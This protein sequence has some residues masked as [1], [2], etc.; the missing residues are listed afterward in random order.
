MKI[1]HTVCSLL[2]LSVTGMPSFAQETAKPAKEPTAEEKAWMAYATPGKAHEMMAKSAGMWSEEVTMWMAPGTEP[3][4]S[5]SNCNNRMIM[6]GRYLEGRSRGTFNGM[7]F[8][9]SS[10]TAYDNAK[11]KY[12][13][14]WIDNMGTGIMV[15]EGTYNEETKTLEM[16]GSC[17]DPGT[18]KDMKTRQTI[19]FIDD[20]NQLM[21]MYMTSNGSEFKSMEIKLTRRVGSTP[22]PPPSTDGK[23]VRPAGKTP[24]VPPAPAEKK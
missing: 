4:K 7:P 20:N 10:I 18:G 13:S 21:T 24:D 6:G 11:K 17:M 2:L 5:N 3:V 23:P 9:G 8:E 1:K 12:V 22:P 19:K 15:S 16:S 14:T